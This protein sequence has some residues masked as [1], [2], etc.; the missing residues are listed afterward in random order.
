MQFRA[1]LPPQLRSGRQFIGPLRLT[2]AVRVSKGEENTIRAFVEDQA[3]EEVIHLEKA[4]SELVGP[5]GHGI[6]DVHCPE[7]RWWV[8]TN[9]TN[10]CSS[11]TSRAATWC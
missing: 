9:P 3:H 7:S 10:R 1:A 6:W 5:V 2:V 4:A 11:R 8:I